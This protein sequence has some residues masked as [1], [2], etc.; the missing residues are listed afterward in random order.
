MYLLYVAGVTY[1]FNQDRLVIAAALVIGALFVAF[2]AARRAWNAPRGARLLLFLT[3]RAGAGLCLLAFLIKPAAL[4]EREW[5]PRRAT[6]LLLDVSESMLIR[7][8]P[9]DGSGQRAP[10]RAA[11]DALLRGRR[12]LAEIAAESDLLFLRFAAGVEMLAGSPSAAGEIF[13]AR[14][15]PFGAATQ[16]A[17]ALRLLLA[18][19]RPHDLDAVILV[20]DGRES[21]PGAWERDYRRLAGAG[22]PPVIAL[23]VGR[24]G[25]PPPL[26]DLRATGL[27]APHVAFTGEE[28]RITA[29]FATTGEGA[30]RVT[31]VA[32]TGSDETPIG[33][34]RW[35]MSSGGEQTGSHGI[36]FGAPG[37][38]RVGLAAR[39]P[40]GMSDVTP[41][42]NGAQT[43]IRVREGKVR[44]AVVAGRAGPEEA[45]FAREL[46]RMPEARVE[47]F[48]LA[49]A[50]NSPRL[51]AT[52]ADWARFD[53]VALGDLGDHA[54][55]SVQRR[56]LLQAAG[57]RP[58]GLLFLPGRLLAAPS[59]SVE[60]DLRALL[61]H[62]P[63]SGA[64]PLAGEFDPLPAG[65]NGGAATGD[66]AAGRH[67]VARALSALPAVSAGAGAGAGEDGARA[68]LPPLSAR[69]EARDLPASST[70]VLVDRRGAPLAVAGRTSGGGRTLSLPG[71]GWWRWGVFSAESARVASAF[72]RGASLWLAGRDAVEG[73][74]AWVDPETFRAPV[75]Q[76]LTILAGEP[77]AAARG[78]ETVPI[79]VRA[80][81]GSGVTLAA[82]YDAARGCFR[83]EFTPALPGEHLIT[84]EPA[85]AEPPANP[86]RSAFMAFSDGLELAAPTADHAALARIAAESGGRFVDAALPFDLAETWRAC[87]RTA[88]ESTT[89][90]TPLWNRW[91]LAALFAAFLG[92]EWTLRR[93]WGHR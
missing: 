4:G 74:S 38:Y 2:L 76:P 82:G 87:R 93:A 25:M 91:W 14:G 11:L 71:V 89:A 47:V 21:Q 6:A 72:V 86:A 52:R 75:G 16:P 7:D 45:F 18:G 27:S 68:A 39:L 63:A 64:G 73:K 80:P 5:R 53:V 22:G 36:M 24:P 9:A 37:L 66:P 85:G 26:A 13:P 59:A 35:E 55:T 57:D 29:R 42:N 19:R 8:G 1:T 3:L 17:A 67:P 88:R 78:A 32:R 34:A 33:A 60:P 48:D 62:Q 83:A 77:S 81:D 31:L 79:A 84:L 65:E 28:A 10:R 23:A 41:D 70:P 90:E 40:P 43:F 54:M 49:L 61:P 51:P 69:W 58:L 44:V 15:A 56:A 12:D 30:A 46:R 50:Q 20:S 92:A